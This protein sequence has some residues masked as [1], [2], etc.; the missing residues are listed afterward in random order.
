MASRADASLEGVGLKEALFIQSAQQNVLHVLQ[1]YAESIGHTTAQPLYGTAP[2]QPAE[3]GSKGHQT[4]QSF[5]RDPSPSQIDVLRFDNLAK[6]LQQARA[7]EDPLLH[8]WLVLWSLYVSDELKARVSRFTPSRLATAY[9]AGFDQRMA[10]YI[11]GSIDYSNRSSPGIM[12][13]EV[14][15]LR[16]GRC[17]GLTRR[18]AAT[19]VSREWHI[20]EQFASVHG[21]AV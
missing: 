15:R 9:F 8:T 13:C 19:A 1:A 2:T 3:A 11:T 21:N 4:S 7:H 18:Q 5:L 14:R 17:T 16:T 10:L 6:E 12:T 20:Y